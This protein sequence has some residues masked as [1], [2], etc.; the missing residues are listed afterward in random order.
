M[1]PI[2]EGVGFSPQDIIIDENEVKQ[3]IEEFTA[4]AGR[5]IKE[6]YIKFR[7]VNRKVIMEDLQLPLN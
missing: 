3:I 5:K 1:L 6:I 4:E 2:L 7:E